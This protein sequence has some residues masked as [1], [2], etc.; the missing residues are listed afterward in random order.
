MKLTVQQIAL[1]S[2]AEIL[3]DGLREITGASSFKDAGPQDLTFA[4]EMPYLKRLHETGAGAVLIPREFAQFDP[5]AVSA[6][7]LRSDQPKLKF[8]R[9][10]SEFYPPDKPSGFISPGAFIGSNCAIGCQVSI[11]NGV[12]VGDDVSIGDRSCLMPG[13]FVGDNTVIGM[14]VTLKPNVT[15][16]DRTII[17]NRVLIHA[18][19][20]IGSDGFGFTPGMSGHEKIPHG[21]YVQIDDDVEIGACNT[22]DRGTFGRT[23]IGRGVKTDNQVHIAHNVTIGENTLVVAQVAIAGSTTIGRN[24]I[25][26]GK[27]GV[28]GHLTVGDGCIIGPGAGVL[29]S[30]PPG[31]IVSGFPHM[32]HRLWLKVGSLLP[33]LPELRKK[34][35]SIEKRLHDHESTGHH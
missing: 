23:W 12:T 30:V 9:V 35:F 6:V 28:S 19:C 34:L 14:D 3:G 8:F 13:V 15:I 2:D 25:I 10:L 33:R 11:G 16:M 27:A 21:G 22:I 32:P 24:V 1:S 5:A 26:A 29:T 4:V 31:Q 7:I 18:G 17:G 20:V